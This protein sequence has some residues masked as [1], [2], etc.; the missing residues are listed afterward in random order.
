MKKFLA[1]TLAALML[2]SLTACGEKDTVDLDAKAEE[3]EA[4]ENLVYGD[5]IYAVNTEGDY[6]ITGYTYN[7][8]ELQKVTVPSEIDSRPVTGIAADAFK[9]CKTLESVTIPTSIKYISDYAFYDCDKLAEVKIPDSVTSIGKGVFQNCDVLKT[10]TFGKSVSSI[11]DFAF[12]DCKV[13]TGVTLPERLVT[14]GKGAFQNCAAITEITVPTTVT[15]IGDGAF[16]NCTSLAKATVMGAAL[17]SFGAIVF[18]NCASGMIVY[19]T[20]GTKADTA[21]KAAGYIVDATPVKVDQ[22]IDD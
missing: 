12:L 20:E 2:L 18:D 5:F 10:V 9:A 6:E 16:Y 17:D 11:G 4:D 15:S 1:I 7:G 14:I 3:V 22:V 8:V 19:T 21:A 13:L